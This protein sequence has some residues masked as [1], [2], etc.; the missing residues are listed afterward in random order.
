MR[1]AC[2]QGGD[3]CLGFIDREGCLGR[4][5]QSLGCGKGELGDIIDALDQVD[6]PAKFRVEMP[7]GALNLRMAGVA[8]QDH[9][10][11]RAGV[12]LHLHM[13]FGDQGTGG[14][15]NPQA[16]CPRSFFDRP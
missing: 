7:H 2:P 10:L 8:D 15:E 1:E 14:I 13:H 6:L 4:V 12:A 3:N 11:A 16:P 9:I 5:G